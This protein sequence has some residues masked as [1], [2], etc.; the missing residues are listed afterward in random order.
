[1]DCSMPGFPV[2]HHLMELAQT[3]VHWISNAIV[4][5]CLV[6]PLS[7]CIQSLPASGSF[8]ISWLFMSGGQS[9]GAS[10]SLLP[11]NIQGWFPLG[12]THLISLLSKGLSRVFYNTTVVK[13]QFVGTQPSFDPTVINTHKI[14]QNSKNVDGRSKKSNTDYKIKY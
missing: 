12:L 3:H 13:H 11:K 9:I 1:M 2:L 8:P 7:F 10:A 5:I 6:S 14:F 4:S